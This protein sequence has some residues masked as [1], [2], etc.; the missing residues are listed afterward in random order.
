MQDVGV[1]VDDHWKADAGI[2]AAHAIPAN[3][4]SF[5]GRRNSSPESE[6]TAEIVAGPQR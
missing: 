4:I 2:V 5:A 1:R 3:C 6:R